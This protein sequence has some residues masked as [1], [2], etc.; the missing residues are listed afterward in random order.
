[1]ALL[2]GS[3]LSTAARSAPHAVAATLGEQAITFADLDRAANRTAHALA[4]LGV[5]RGDIVAWWTGPGL[6]SLEAMVA[7]ARLGAVWPHST[8][9]SPRPRSRRP[10]ST[11]LRA[12]W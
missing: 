3:I 7:T 6:R 4:G 8:R 2:I 10:S 1:M 11:W 12:C 5:A 9:P